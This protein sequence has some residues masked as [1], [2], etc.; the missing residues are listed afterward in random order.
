MPVKQSE[1]IKLRDG[2]MKI[3]IPYSVNCSRCII[4]TSQIKK[5][6][7]I[8]ELYDSI[9]S[10]NLVV[11]E[12]LTVFPQFT[13]HQLN[14]FKN[15]T[16]LEIESLYKSQMYPNTIPDNIWVVFP[17]ITCLC[18]H[19]IYIPLD[20]L[21]TLELSKF[22]INYKKLPTKK[23]KEHIQD[24]FNVVEQMTTLTEISITSYCNIIVSDSLFSNNP[25]LVNV[26]IWGAGSILDNIPSIINCK[27]L[28]RLIC[29]IDIF[30]NPYILDISNL[31]FASI[32][33]NC[34]KYENIEIPDYIFAKPIFTTI[35][36]DIYFS[37]NI[38]NIIN[39][40][41]IQ[42]QNLCNIGYDIN[43][44]VNRNGYENPS[45]YN[46]IHIERKKVV[47]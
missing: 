42:F 18:C 27:D 39:Q 28:K 15:I 43:V 41:G 10:L 33:T 37:V 5:L 30:K 23:M 6:P 36:S 17:N 35:E 29:N 26:S 9:I 3:N 13:Q 44:F 34:D 40:N 47:T 46:S 22:S 11:D 31:K 45:T 21:N 25:G 14:M 12:P 1:L 24:I 19:Y 20:N 32:K 7:L 4:R 38:E 2:N 16:S 8:L